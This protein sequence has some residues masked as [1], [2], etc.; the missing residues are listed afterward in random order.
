MA[1]DNKLRSTPAVQFIQSISSSWKGYELFAIWI[2]KKLKPKVTVDLGFDMGLSTISFAHGNCGHTFGIDWLT[3]ANF[4]RKRMAMESAFHN[5]L[6]AIRL[7]YVKNLHLII[8]P[9]T[10][11]SNKW[12]K[13]IDLLH[14]DCTQHYEDI[15]KQ[16][17]HWKPF[18]KKDS[19]ILIHDVASF[20]SEIGRF[21]D[22]LPLSKLLF[23]HGKGLGLATGNPSL[24]REIAE[25]WRF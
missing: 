19:I 8:G 2:V 7:K 1:R 24:C 22:E 14:I 9:P 6:N 18:L 5:I 17:E 10:E 11:I 25:E 4:S 15:Q 12:N 20:P 23:T 16:Y 13:E 21:F 3:D